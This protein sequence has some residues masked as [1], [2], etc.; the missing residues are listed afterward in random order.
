MC[1]GAFEE[2]LEGAC[3][4][5]APFFDTGQLLRIFRQLAQEARDH[6]EGFRGWAGFCV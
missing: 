1:E 5:G 3:E 4:D 2:G 6:G